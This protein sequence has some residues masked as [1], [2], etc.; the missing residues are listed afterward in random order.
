MKSIFIL[1][2]CCALVSGCESQRGSTNNPLP[3]AVYQEPHHRVVLQNDY[4]RILDIHL[5]PGESTLFHVHALPT[6]Y[7]TFV[8]SLTGEREP[9][10]EPGSPEKVEGG[11]V[12]LNAYDPAYTHQVK[13]HGATEY[14]GL[15]IELLRK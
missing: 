12:G 6:V 8:E 5:P 15:D 13:N 11:L 2:S 14:R 10:K 1:V 4:V 7:A 9:G 3:V